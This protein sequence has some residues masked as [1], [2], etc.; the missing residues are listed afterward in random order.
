MSTSIALIALL[1]AVIGGGILLLIASIRG[2]DTKPL[3]AGGGVRS[4]VELIGRQTLI[5]IGAGVLVLVITRWPVAAVGA[6]VLVAFW[7]A[8]FGGAKAERD[9][10]ARIDG[11]ASWVESLRDTIA[12]AVGLEQAIPSTVYAAAPS[13][14]PQLR[15]LSDRLR[16]RVPMPE[17]LQRFADDLDDASAD[18]I[19]AALIL[20]AKLRGPGLRQVLSSLAESARAE[21]DMRQRV[22]AGRASTRR[23]V[24]IVVG[25]SIAFMVGLRVLNPSYVEP[26]SA[27][28]GQVV[29]VVIMA[30]FGAGFLWMR[31]LA[32]FETPA[33]FLV[34]QQR[35]SSEV[36]S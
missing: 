22:Y 2:F 1:G 6:G 27:P 17:A 32:A 24:Q 36:G 10:I 5:G 21:L 11:L 28:L 9:A 8:L 7:P 25:V 30:L 13:I 31:R 18:L 16:I 12:G 3:E 19:V 33:R 15:L 35:M 23:S 34:S 26:Y 4:L 14:Q 20:N 29:L